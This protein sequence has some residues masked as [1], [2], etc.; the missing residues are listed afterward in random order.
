MEAFGTTTYSTTGI[1]DITLTDKKTSRAPM[2]IYYN[3]KRIIYIDFSNIKKTEEIY[4]L[5]EEAKRFIAV[6]LP[7]SVLTLTNLTGMHF[8][9][10]VFNRFTAYVKVNAPYVKASAVVGM[11]GMMQIFYNSFT[12]ITGRDVKAFSTEYEAKKYL[13]E[14]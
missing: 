1:M 2:V 8:N 7:K 4:A 11:N 6:N 3:Q 12:R 14:K 5:M 13:A 10:E 9:N